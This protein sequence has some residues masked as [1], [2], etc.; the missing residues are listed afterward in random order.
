[1][2]W[3]NYIQYSCHPDHRVRNTPNAWTLCEEVEKNCPPFM[4]IPCT[5]PGELDIAVNETCPDCVAARPKTPP[6]LP[7]GWY[8][9]NKKSGTEAEKLETAHLI[10]AEAKKRQQQR[11]DDEEERKLNKKGVSLIPPG[12][13]RRRH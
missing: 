6:G 9:Q 1:M 10:V 3:K 2:C 4:K 12:G 13:A 11:K 5:E 7:P 8:S